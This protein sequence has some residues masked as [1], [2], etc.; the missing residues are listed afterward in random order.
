MHKINGSSPA[1]FED[2]K[3]RWL[4]DTC[5]PL[6][7]AAE[8]GE[9]DLHARSRGAYPGRQ[10]ADDQF[11]GLLSVGLW[12]AGTDQS[13]GLDWHRNEGLEL[14]F[15]ERGRLPFSCDEGEYDLAPR[16]LTVTRPWQ[17]HRVGRPTIT[18]SRL[19]W[20][21]L[22]LGVRRPNEQWRWPSWIL[23]DPPRLERLTTKLRGN[24]QHVWHADAEVARSFAAL[25]QVLE[26]DR[27]DLVVRVALCI[28]EILLAL[29][30]LF[31]R[32]DVALDGFLRS[33]ERTVDLFLAGL[34]EHVG[35]I[36]TV[37]SMAAACGL[38]R[39]RFAQ[40]CRELT[41]MTPLEYLM[42]QRLDVAQDLL[43]DRDDLRVADV[44]RLTGF[45]S[46]Q[47][48]ATVMRR[49][50]GCSPSDLRRAGVVAGVAH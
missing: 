13:W 11:P 18:A 28:N 6:K 25:G 50:L 21:I 19:Y 32:T 43:R 31:D 14:T 44:A 23:F 33:S 9:V 34:R 10:L 24:E 48:F 22:D 5:D 45:G 41:N 30:D 39:T 7:S 49:E 2:G 26:G 40:Y 17:R 38:G 4:A 47:Y 42:R 20:V 16:D 29:D 27:D 46:S 37:D 36:W 8:R 15:V 1:V 35:E 12:D 3:Q